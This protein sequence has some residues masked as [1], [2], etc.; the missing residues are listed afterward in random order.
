MQIWNCKTTRRKLE[1][2]WHWPGQSFAL[3]LES[4]GNKSRNKHRLLAARKFLHSRGRKGKDTTWK[5]GKYLQNILL[6]RVSN[7]KYMSSPNNSVARMETIQ[8]KQNK[9]PG[10]PTQLGPRP[11]ANSLIDNQKVQKG[12]GGV[13]GGGREIRGGRE[14]V[15]PECTVYV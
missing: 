15:Q 7:P 14:W 4:R 10:E 8:W 2:P 3:D 11:W 9:G 5:A 13:D 6:K 12:R 1:V